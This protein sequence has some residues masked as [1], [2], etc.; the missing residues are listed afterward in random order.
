[1]TEMPECPGCKRPI[2]PDVCWCGDMM[3]GMHD[4]HYGVPMGCV[5]LS[6]SIA[7]LTEPEKEK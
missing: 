2:D 3:G 1:M 7:L 6:S 4:N 5:C